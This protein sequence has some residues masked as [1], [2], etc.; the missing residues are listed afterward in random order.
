MIHGCPYLLGDGRIQSGLRMDSE[1]LIPVRLQ[2]LIRDRIPVWRSA[3]GINL[4]SGVRGRIPVS[5]LVQLIGIK[6]SRDRCVHDR[7]G[8]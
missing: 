7:I 5:S 2:N 1:V 8:Q 3:N 4:T 6:R